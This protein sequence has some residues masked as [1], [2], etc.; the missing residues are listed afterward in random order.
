L[1]QPGAQQFGFDV[2]VVG[3]VGP[4]AQVVVAQLLLEQRDDALL[5]LFSI[6]PTGVMG[7]SS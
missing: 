4:V 2:G 6:W 7:F 5:G 1:L 3:A